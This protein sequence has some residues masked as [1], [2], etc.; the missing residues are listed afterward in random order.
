MGVNIIRI[1][2]FLIF[3]FSL[4]SLKL[5]S[6]KIR[7]T[8][9]IMGLQKRSNLS[10]EKSGRSRRRCDDRACNIPDPCYRSLERAMGR[11]NVQAGQKTQWQ[12][13]HGLNK[14][15]IPSNDSDLAKKREKMKKRSW[16]ELRKSGTS[17]TSWAS[18]RT[19]RAVSWTS[20]LKLDQ[21]DQLV[22]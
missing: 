7:E 16:A 10:S 6:R 21:L 2:F 5:K 20:S 12:A 4:L 1:F 11:G 22:D 3:G 13:F 9:K 17:W 8:S 18:W 19:G 14:G 15:L